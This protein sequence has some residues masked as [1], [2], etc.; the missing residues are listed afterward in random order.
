MNSSGLGVEVSSLQLNVKGLL[1]R[2]ATALVYVLCLQSTFGADAP[3]IKGELFLDEGMAHV[4]DCRRHQEI[5]VWPLASTQYLNLTR[6]YK[7]ASEDGKFKV[8][9]AMKG[10]VHAQQEQCWARR[11]ACH[12]P[13]LCIRC[14]WYLRR[15]SVGRVMSG[16]R[17]GSP[18][19][20]SVA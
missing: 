12:E 15:Y 2:A 19:R 6:Q 10:T 1:R 8:L 13:D 5:K 20:R 17:H 9:V 14:S 11:V 7:E 16:R 18:C 4:W 3:P